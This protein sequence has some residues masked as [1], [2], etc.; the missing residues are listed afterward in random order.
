MFKVSVMWLL[1]YILTI[2]PGEQQVYY[3]EQSLPE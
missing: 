3:A 1:L 2:Q